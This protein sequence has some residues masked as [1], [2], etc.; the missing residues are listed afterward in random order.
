MRLKA[1]RSLLFLP[2]TS[3]QLLA[4]AME[5]GADALIVDLEDSVPAER[6]A[7]ARPLAAAALRALAARGAEVL[8]RVNADPAL[9]DDDLAVLP[10]DVPVTVMLPKVEDA[11]QVEALVAKLSGLGLTSPIAALVETP[12]GALEA[13]RIAAAPGVCAVGFGAEDFAASV[14]LAPSPAALSIPAQLVGLAAHAHGHAFWGLAGS[15]AETVDMEAFGA[16]VRLSRQL[17]FTG[18]VCI[19]PRQVPVVNAGFGP[20]P[21]EIDWARRVVA[22]AEEARARGEGAFLLDGRM[23]DRPIED[24]ARRW[25]AQ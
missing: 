20:T 22:A 25:L 17:G 1:A 15:V 21:E 5:R 9:H 18:S 4:K 2:A 19:H 8:L 7:E 3:P 12:R 11:A 14:G 13:P 24:R 6:K 10:R 23:I 16:L